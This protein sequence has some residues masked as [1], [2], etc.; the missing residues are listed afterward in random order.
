METPQDKGDVRSAEVL[1]FHAY[2]QRKVAHKGGTV[3]E[4]PSSTYISLIHLAKRAA[5]L[6]CGETLDVRRCELEHLD[7]R[8][9]SGRAVAVGSENISLLDL[10]RDFVA[11][12]VAG[13]AAR[14]D[15]QRRGVT[16]IDAIATRVWDEVDDGISR[17]T[18]WD[19]FVEA[20]HAY[21]RSIVRPQ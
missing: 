15:L 20:V 11:F 1:D 16:E 14:E 9:R 6:W 7:I 17:I 2:L 5:F 3:Q 18:N 12:R 13:L 10:D 19:A 21:C 8:D 4:I